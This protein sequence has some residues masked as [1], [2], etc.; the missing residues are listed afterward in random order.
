MSTSQSHFLGGVAEVSIL[1]GDTMFAK[2]K[3]LLDSSITIGVSNVEVRGG[4]GAKLLGKYFHTTKFDAK[5]TDAMFRM[6]YISKNVGQNITIGTT[7]VYT[8][9]QVTLAQGGIGTITGDAVDFEGYG[10]VGWVKYPLEATYTTVIIA[11]DKTFTVPNGKKDDV[12]CIEYSVLDAAA[13]QLVIPSNMIPSTVRLIFKAE[14][15][16][17]DNTDP[18]S[19]SLV[20]YV[21]IEVPRFILSGNQAISMTMNGV[22]NT[23]LEGSALSNDATDCAG[24]GYYA[25]IKEQMINANWYDDVYALAVEGGEVDVTVGAGTETLSVM[26]LH[27]Y[28]MPS[29]APNKDLHFATSDGAKATVG[30]NTGIVTPVGAGNCT[31]TIYITNKS[32]V[33]AYVDVV[34]SAAP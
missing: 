33:L 10:L 4:T 2:A 25:L 30:T 31:I 32:T 5:L 9:E 34:V 22:S 16:A 19:A 8:S 17:G 28:F 29:K 23:P 24:V 27:P 21:F 26:A 1:D 12:V 13:R 6:E 11:G 18:N 20:G 7:D 14:L 15:F 3:T